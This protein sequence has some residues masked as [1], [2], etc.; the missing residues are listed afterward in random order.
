MRAL[1]EALIRS[2]LR[3]VVP[4]YIRFQ[5]SVKLFLR[6]AGRETI[7]TLHL[8]LRRRE[9][10]FHQ[11]SFLFFVVDVKHFV[12]DCWKSSSLGCE[13]KGAEA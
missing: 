1:W 13:G 5:E 3:N 12:G 7:L 9:E 2:V 11:F 4:D 6:E 10:A 8:L